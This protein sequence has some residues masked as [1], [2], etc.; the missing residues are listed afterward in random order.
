MRDV[1]ERIA[2]LSPEQRALLE[3]RLQQKRIPHAPETRIPTRHPSGPCPL[4]FAQQRL[5]FLD[6]LDLPPALYTVARALRLHGRLDLTAMQ[7]SLDALVQR[8]DILRTTFDMVQGDPVQIVGISRPVDLT[9]LDLPARSEAEQPEQLHRQMSDAMQRPFDLSR[10]LLLR[11]ALFKRAADD[12][13][14]LL[15]APHIVCDAWSMEILLR[16]L[17]SFYTAFINGHSASLDVLPIQYADYTAW[18]HQT[19]QGEW[20]DTHLAFWQ[21]QLRGASPLLDLPTDRPRPA[22]QRYCGAAQSLYLSPSLTQALTALSQREGVTLFTTL[23]AAWQILAYRYT[24]QE[25]IVLGSPAAG[26]SRVE[27]EA[28]IGLFINTVVLRTSLNGDLVFR[29]LLQRTREVVINAVAHQEMPFEKLVEALQPER[30]LSYAPLVQVLFTLQNVPRCRLELPGLTVQ[31][32]AVHTGMARFDLT[33]TLWEE[34]GALTGSLEY[35]TDLFDD[36]TITRMRGHWQTLLE[37]IVA[38][39]EQ[40]VARLP[41]LSE[42]ETTQLLVEWNATSAPFPHEVCLHQ[43]I[44]QQAIRTPHATAVSDA[45]GTLTY[46]ELNKRANQLAHHL[47]S[48]GVGPDTLV[49]LC[50]Q[51]SRSMLVGLLGILKAGGAYVPLDP[52]YPRERLRFM[53]DDA[54]VSVMV[55]DSQGRAAAPVHPAQVVCLDSHAEFWR[56]ADDTNPIADTTPEHLAYV[57]YTSGSTGLP[58]GVQIPHRAVVNFLCAMQRQPGISPQDVLLAVTTLSFDIAVLELFLPLTVGAQLILASQSVAADGEQLAEQL[59][60]TRATLMQATPATWRLLLEAGWQGNENLRI[61]CG[62]EALPQDLADVLVARGSTLWNLYGPTETTIWSMVANIDA[63]ATPVSLGTPIANTRIYVLDQHCRPVPVGVPGE[64]FIGGAG[65]ARGYLNRP[66]LTAERF[67]SLTLRETDAERLYRT[68]DLARY[69]H[70]GTLEFLGRMDDQVKIR[71]FRIELGEIETRLHEHPAVDQAVVVAREVS[72]GD[73]RLVA[74]FLPSCLM[75]AEPA[76]PDPTVLRRYLQETLPDYMIPSAFVCVDGWPQ[77]LNGKID[78]QALPQ[79]DSTQTAQ[80]PLVTAP[81]DALERQLAQVWEEV[82]GVRPIGMHDDFFALGGHSLLAVRLFSRLK[83]LCGVP[84][85]LATLFQAPTVAQL[86]ES[87]RQE[88]WSP[89]W[90]SLVSLQPTGS[91]HP[92]Y[93][94]HAH[95]GHVLFYYDLAHGLDTDQPVFGLQAHGLDDAQLRHTRVEEMAAHYIEEIRTFQPHGPYLLAGFCLGG[96]VAYEMAQQLR[97]QG[98]PIGFLALL[99]SNATGGRLATSDTHSRRYRWQRKAQRA[100]HYIQALRLLERKDRLSF[101]RLKAGN[102]MH[103]LLLAVQDQLER[104][105]PLKRLMPPR[106]QALEAEPYL[107]V[108]PY[109]PG[110]YPGDMT[111]FQASTQGAGFVQDEW[112]GWGELVKGEITIH[113]IPGYRETML[114]PPGVRLLARKLQACLDDLHDRQDGRSD[115]DPRRLG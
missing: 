43:L 34:Q 51:R 41:L 6:Q 26:R 14:L 59:A 38:H 76:P 103:K 93:C 31:P 109:T 56:Q 50:L 104:M 10:D 13:V 52:A 68:G 83:S 73:R 49:A 29:D 92:L 24:G 58:K 48:L 102:A 74:Y 88:A 62:G 110:V 37:G 25:D 39:P 94:I 61:L 46:A 106:L 1:H 114:E 42:A 4:S 107:T 77:T 9:V 85:P 47:Q 17:G 80:S 86:A 12:H 70:D 95:G 44:E 15:L 78:R 89:P 101:L 27:T 90:S 35:N 11:A 82:L 33:L 36:A 63:T 108:E 20:L 100:R 23:F 57:I 115:C 99:D 79:P 87:L 71:G 111:L 97:A 40:S 64:M 84:L 21:T 8:H 54:Q 45:V 7:H 53:L 19:V 18:Q 105:P 75:S 2:N 67:V 113:T 22:M 112:M 81:Q 72:P 66:E 65:V 96:L 28:L 3:R 5:W 98:Q 60:S 91:K 69:R 30:N 16:E 55:T 32:I